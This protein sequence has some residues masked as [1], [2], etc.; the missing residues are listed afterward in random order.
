MWHTKIKHAL[1]LLGI[2]QMGLTA[3]H[4]KSIA[5]G[6]E[7]Y[8]TGILDPGIALNA[9]FHFELGTFGAFIPDE[10]NIPL[11][12]ANWKLLDST[13]YN[14]TTRLFTDTATPVYNAVTSTWSPSAT[15]A[16]QPGAQFS[17]GE[18]VYIFVYNYTT[19]DANSQWGAFTRINSLDPANPD[20]VLPGG[21][22][23]QTSFPQFMLQ[24]DVN[25][26]LSNV[27]EPGSVMLLGLIGAL[28]FTRRRRA[29]R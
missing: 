10:A 6:N 20:W 13:T 1:C 21:P 28:N 27:P 4:A 14:P 23:N 19:L 26:T 5:W 22:G 2:A 15:D 12:K 24:A 9:M 3:A 16:P 25:Q 8:G 7:A 11:W 29:A 17:E 18:Q